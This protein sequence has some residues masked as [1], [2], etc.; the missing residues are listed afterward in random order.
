MSQKDLSKSP[1]PLSGTPRNLPENCELVLKITREKKLNYFIYIPVIV[2]LQPP[3]PSVPHPIS[4]PFC[5]GKGAL[6]CTRPPL[7]W[8]PQVSPGFKYIFS[9]CGRPGRLC[10]TCA[11]ALDQPGYAP[12]WW[13]SLWELPGVWAS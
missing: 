4:P 11:R 7:S 3:P 13:L 9:H 1:I 6:S 8:G 2:S 12:G 10:Y 5:L